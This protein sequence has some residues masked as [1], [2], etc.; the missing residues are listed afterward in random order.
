MAAGD[1]KNPLNQMQMQERQS[2]S[3]GQNEPLPTDRKASTIPMADFHPAHQDASA[4][5]G[6]WAFFFDRQIGGRMGDVCGA[7]A[8]G[9]GAD[10]C[11][12]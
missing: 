2:P 5:V 6:G 1:E 4:K 3:V 7:A 11:A 12:A 10:W 8:R 9:R